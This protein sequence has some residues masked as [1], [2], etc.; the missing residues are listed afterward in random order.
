MFI[1]LLVLRQDKTVIIFLKSICMT[2][3]YLSG[4][5]YQSLGARAGQDRLHLQQPVDDEHEAQVRRRAGGSQ[6]RGK[7]PPQQVVG[8]GRQLSRSL[9]VWFLTPLKDN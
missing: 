2:I 7:Q 5:I 6:P 9:T 4:F 8:A 3:Y 1:L